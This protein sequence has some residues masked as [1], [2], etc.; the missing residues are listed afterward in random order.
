MTKLKI[1]QYWTNFGRPWYVIRYGH[2]PT[3]Y[4]AVQHSK[5][6]EYLPIAWM[7]RNA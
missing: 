3:D 2:K 5:L 1:R 6:E 4:F 7:M